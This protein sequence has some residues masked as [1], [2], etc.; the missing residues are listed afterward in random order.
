MCTGVCRSIAGVCVGVEVSVCRCR[1]VCVG[2]GVCG[3][4]CE[5]NFQNAIDGIEL[6][7]LGLLARAFTHCVIVL[8]P[9]KGTSFYPKLA[10]G[11]QRAPVSKLR[12]QQRSIF[13]YSSGKCQLLNTFPSPAL[14]QWKVKCG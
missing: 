12:K 9:I 1:G 13:I 11:T 5:D 3:C 4:G 2:I 6:R 8:A 14:R 10:Q 7:S